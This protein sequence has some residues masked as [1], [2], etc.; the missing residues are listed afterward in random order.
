MS[1]IPPKLTKSE[2]LLLQH[3][4]Q[5]VKI[6]FILYKTDKIRHSEIIR[7]NTIYPGIQRK[8]SRTFYKMYQKLISS[9]L[10]TKIKDITVN[11]QYYAY[12][13]TQDA[14]EYIQFLLNQPDK[15]NNFSFLDYQNY[16]LPQEKPTQT[17][18]TTISQK[19]TPTLPKSDLPPQNVEDGQDTGKVTNFLMDQI[20]ELNAKL[21]RY[22]SSNFG[23]PPPP[24]PPP[25]TYQ[26]HLTPAYNSNSQAH[27]SDYSRNSNYRRNREPTREFQGFADPRQYE[28]EDNVDIQGNNFDDGGAVSHEVEMEI[29]EE[30]EEEPEEEIIELTEEEKHRLYLDGLSNAEYLGYYTNLPGTLLRS[31]ETKEEF[32]MEVDRRKLDTTEK[33]QYFQETLQ[34]HPE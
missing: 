3:S 24:T 21:N 19:I 14:R 13:I 26:T 4:S 7:L 9:K 22:E 30:I 23:Y 29:E 33:H 11:R 6:L 34:I 27:G 17:P 10:I 12:S 2:E 15:K 32:W 5:E 20:K 25:Q 28:D 18:T 8:S 1:K 16:L 31:E